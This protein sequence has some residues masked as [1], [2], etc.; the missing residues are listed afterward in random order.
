ME[1]ICNSVQIDWNLMYEE[2]ELPED[3]WPEE[4]AQKWDIDNQILP[5]LQHVRPITKFKPLDVK[6]INNTPKEIIH[7]QHKRN[8]S[9]IV[10]EGFSITGKELKVESGYEQSVGQKF[11]RLAPLSKS[12]MVS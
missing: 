5:P 9:T 12:V 8:E 2:D 7:M 1:L 11:Y 3:Y 6:D 10:R 4:R